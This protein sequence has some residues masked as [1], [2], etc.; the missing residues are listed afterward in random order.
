MKSFIICREI[1]GFGFPIYRNYGYAWGRDDPVD[2]PP[3]APTN[4][5]PIGKYRRTFQVP[6]SWA[7]RNVLVHF[8]AVD[9]AFYVFVNGQEVGY[10]QDSRTPAEFDITG[11]LIDGEDQVIAVEVYRWNVGS[12]IE[13]QVLVASLQSRSR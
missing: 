3:N 12:W 11:H 7:E 9:S 2:N 4:F 1:K 13:D 5:N 8:E 6:E 10:S